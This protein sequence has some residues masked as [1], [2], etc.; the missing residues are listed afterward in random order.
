MISIARA[1][2]HTSFGRLIL[3][4]A[5]LEL[6]GFLAVRA[7]G[8]AEHPMRSEQVRILNTENSTSLVM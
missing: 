5:I 6:C 1:S 8:N 3:A 2:S 7:V 4:A